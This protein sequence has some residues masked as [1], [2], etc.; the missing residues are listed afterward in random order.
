M[1]YICPEVTTHAIQFECAMLHNMRWPG[2]PGPQG[3]YSNFD[4]QAWSNHVRKACCRALS[5]TVLPLSADYH[6]HRARIDKYLL[7]M[8]EWSHAMR[9]FAVNL[10]EHQAQ[11]QVTMN[12]SCT[13]GRVRTLERALA[14]MSDRVHALE[15]ALALNDRVR[16]LEQLA[17]SQ[18]PAA[19]TVAAMSEKAP[20]EEEQRLPLTVQI[21]NAKRRACSR[22]PSP[23]RLWIPDGG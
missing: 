14:A 20:Q 6:D 12:M 15:Q 17:A 7:E 22:S 9:D 10:Q 19:A 5:S 21:R 23:T 1:A 4:M 8:N 13:N 16:T 2:Q 18:S 3:H 11:Q